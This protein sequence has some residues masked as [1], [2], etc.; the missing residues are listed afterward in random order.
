M[1]SRM[2]INLVK[3]TP[4]A[5]HSNPSDTLAI[6][7]GNSTAAKLTIYLRVRYPE[8]NWQL[9]KLY[10]NCKED[11]GSFV[12]AI[13][14]RKTAI[15]LAALEFSRSLLDEKVQQHKKINSAN[16]AIDYVC[17]RYLI[18]LR[19]VGKEFFY[20]VLL[21]IRNNII[22]D[23]EISRGSISASVVDPADIVREACIHH[24]NR[25]ILVHN[26]PSGETDPSKED[27]DTTNKIVQAL[28]YVGIKVLDH[29]I[30]GRARQD[31]Y[32]FAKAGLV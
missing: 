13:G 21:D 27:I 12:T 16:D 29:V 2:F 20:I 31:F 5:Y 30:V 19:D 3:D 8:G 4:S 17:D 14:A 23:V 28:K 24:A 18:Q 26:H 10:L 7:L 15:L 11:P 9:N 22:K 25:V 32:S 1:N 6:L